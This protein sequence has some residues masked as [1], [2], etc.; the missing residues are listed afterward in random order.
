VTRLCEQLTHYEDKLKNLE[1][2]YE[3]NQRWSVSSTEYC[4][5][6]ALVSSENRPHFLL[7]IEQ[8]AR[9]RWYLLKLEANYAG[10]V[11]MLY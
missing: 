4:E 2:V 7:K 8:A 11:L 10:T 5:V 6:K 1:E 9:E 3:I